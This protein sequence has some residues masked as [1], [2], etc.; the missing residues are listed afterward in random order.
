MKYL[1]ILFSSVILL[2]ACNKA[3]VKS[4]VKG[5]KFGAEMTT[6]AA[7]AASEIKQLL[8]GKDSVQ[9]KLEAKIT[10]CCQMKGC[11][12][13]VDIGNGE[14]MHVSFKDYGF[15]VPKDA[16]GKKTIMEGVARRRVVEA[17]ELQHR[18]KDEGKSEEEIAAITSPVE[19]Y[20]F[21]ANGL[22]IQ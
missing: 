19:E 6:E 16:A 17:D 9:T 2:S 3:P 1:L 10:Q 20:E 8:A 15:F 13:T 7:V 5:E 11:W 4:E 21:V 12:M 18:A 14:A 22:V